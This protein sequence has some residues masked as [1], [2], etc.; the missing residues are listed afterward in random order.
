[1]ECDT[2]QVRGQLEKICSHP[3]AFR[4]MHV[5][6]VDFGSVLMWLVRERERDWHHNEIEVVVDI[7]FILNRY[8]YPLRLTKP[9]C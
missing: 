4:G 1:M 8:C 5:L 3:A 6:C 2:A 9:F 7:R